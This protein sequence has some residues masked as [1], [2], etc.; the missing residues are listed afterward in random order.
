M[1]QLGFALDNA[2]ASRP[3][4][5]YAIPRYQVSLV[6]DGKVKTPIAQIRS[7]RDAREILAAY[8][9]DVDR[10]HFVVLLLD[11]KNRIIGIHTVST[12]SLTASVVHPREV[13][14]VAI[15]SNAAAIVAGHN[16]PSGDPNPSQ[17]DRVLTERLRSACKI[18]GIGLLD[19][20]I[21]GDGSTAYY[22]FADEGLLQ[23]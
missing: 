21:V 16:H 7:S 3:E 20:V 17:E 6:R 22:S 23:P 5:Q 9:A 8:L 10:E 18:M 1:D 11:Q 15:L 13:L 19:H 12:G 14:K 2:P 4:K